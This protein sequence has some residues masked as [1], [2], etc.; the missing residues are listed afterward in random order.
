MYVTRYKRLHKL[1]SLVSDHVRS[2]VVLYCTLLD[3]AKAYSS[4][5]RGAGALHRE[6]VRGL[7]RCEI[8]LYINMIISFQ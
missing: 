3:A 8:V 7:G 4:A 1:Y 5:E 6:E 2:P